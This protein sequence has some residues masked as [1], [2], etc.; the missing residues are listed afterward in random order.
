MKHLQGFG[1]TDM[2]GRTAYDT[3]I[4]G[5]NKES[6]AEIYVLGIKGINKEKKDC[7]NCASKKD[8]YVV[9]IMQSKSAFMLYLLD[10][11]TIKCIHSLPK[12]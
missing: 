12:S 2:L 10:L 1:I 4:K 9:V 6:C 5:C 8:G 3:I 7:G 11:V